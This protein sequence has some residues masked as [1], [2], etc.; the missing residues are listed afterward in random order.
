MVF[1]CD[2]KSYD[3]AEL[4][5]YATDDTATPFIYAARDFTS[6]FVMTIDRYKGVRVHRADDVEIKNLAA[7]YGFPGIL[8]ALSPGY[9]SDPTTSGEWANNRS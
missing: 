7:R 2:G 3:S 5:E 8:R 1:A 4:I 6:I 9:L